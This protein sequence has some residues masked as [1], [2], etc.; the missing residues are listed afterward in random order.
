MI[1]SSSGLL[2]SS[3]DPSAAKNLAVHAVLSRVIASV[4]NEGLALGVYNQIQHRG[5][6]LPLSSNPSEL[7]D[8][9][10]ITFP[11]NRPLY[12]DPF[13]DG[14]NLDCLHIL[15]ADPEDILKRDPGDYCI[16]RANGTSRLVETGTEVMRIVQ[17]WNKI[18]TSGFEDLMEEL[19]NTLENANAT[20]LSSQLTPTL[21]SEYNTW[22]QSLV[23]GHSTHPVRGLYSYV[24]HIC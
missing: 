1:E 22:E 6:L 7:N 10:S 18:Q 8:S 3:R 15:F 14:L 23:D 24:N 20:Y 17:E 21:K 9:Q 4:I 5:S 12:T 16:I 13:N 11:M 19:R 2:L